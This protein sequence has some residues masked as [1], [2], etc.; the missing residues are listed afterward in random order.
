MI[1]KELA[2]ASGV[3]KRALDTY[4]RTK[5]CMPPADIA[6]KIA[7]ALGVT[8]EYLVTGENLSIPPDIRLISRNLLKLN[9][10]DRRVVP[11]MVEAMIERLEP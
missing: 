11:I 10:K 3:N 1:I 2:S 4:L 8:V 9:K 5:P 7:R 6:V